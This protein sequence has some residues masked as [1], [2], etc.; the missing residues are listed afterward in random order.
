MS[1]TTVGDIPD[2][3]P[4]SGRCWKT[5]QRTR[6]SSQV[7]KGVLSHLSSTFEE[8][9]LKASRNAETKALE[10]DIKGRAKALRIEK[11]EKRLEKSKRRQANE[12]KN[13]SF[14][15]IDGTKMKHM[16]KKQLRMIKKTI[17]NKDGQVLIYR[18]SSFASFYP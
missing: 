17:V 15:I 6:T 10:Q 7:R 4:K 11:K 3:M 1:T 5:K 12:M 16:N 2:G 8:R 18:L 13:S 14:Q 9:Q